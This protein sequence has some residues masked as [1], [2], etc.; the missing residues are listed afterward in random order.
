M[1][2]SEA[3]RK[4]PWSQSI[5]PDLQLPLLMVLRSCPGS[6]LFC[7][8]LLGQQEYLEGSLPGLTDG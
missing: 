6:T 8:F 7:S 5:F 4:A 3:G 1:S 2:I